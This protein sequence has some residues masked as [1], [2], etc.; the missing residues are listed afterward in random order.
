MSSRAQWAGLC[1]LLAERYACHA[2]DLLGYGDAPFPGGPAADFSLAVE[3]AAAAAAIDAE[4]GPER[5]FHLVGHSYGG[6]TALRLARQMGARIL[7]LAVFEPVAFHLLERGDPAR[8]EIEDVTTRIAA[9][10]TPRDATRIFIDY[11]NRPG[12]FDGAPP[13]M[14][15]RFTAQIA[16]VMLDFQALIGDPAR[17]ADL[18]ALDLPALVLSGQASPPSTRQLA[19]QLAAVLPRASRAETRGGHMAPITHAAAVNPH[20]A[21]F[22]D[23]QG[24]KKPGARPGFR[25]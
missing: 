24:E 14:Q 22:L 12:A 19:Q 11:W 4:L 17:L 21:G 10:A 20:I 16:K 25:C 3:A 6:A 23:R 1:A 5:P 8:A 7:S 18:A 13:A 2:I 15:D 9:A